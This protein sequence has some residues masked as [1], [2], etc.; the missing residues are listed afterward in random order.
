MEWSCLA[1]NKCI[2]K[3][4]G[5]QENRVSDPSFTFVIATDGLGRARLD[6][7]TGVIPIS[8]TQVVLIAAL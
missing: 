2:S 7:K 3:S 5:L 4:G 8:L 1:P 6:Y